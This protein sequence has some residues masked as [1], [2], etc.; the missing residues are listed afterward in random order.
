MMNEFKTPIKK[1]WQLASRP[2][3]VVAPIVTDAAPTGAPQVVGAIWVDTSGPAI[4][5]SSGVSS[6]TDWRLIWD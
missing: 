1:A 6:V 4:W 2:A 3:E 5:I